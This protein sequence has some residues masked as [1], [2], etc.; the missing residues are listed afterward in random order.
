M[1]TIFLKIHE[2]EYGC[3]INKTAEETQIRLK[4]NKPLNMPLTED[5]TKLHTF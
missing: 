5:I 3:Y 2:D 4:R 1:L